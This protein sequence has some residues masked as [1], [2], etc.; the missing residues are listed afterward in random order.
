[1]QISVLHGHL[2]GQTAHEVL[3]KG[4]RGLLGTTIIDN[5]DE[6]QETPVLALL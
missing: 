4:V 5:P 2:V 1:V 3:G 6:E